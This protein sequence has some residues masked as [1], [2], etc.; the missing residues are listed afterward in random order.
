MTDSYN[1]ACFWLFERG[2]KMEERC[3]A[4]ERKLIPAVFLEEVKHFPESTFFGSNI[5][6]VCGFDEPQCQSLDLFV[7]VN[8]F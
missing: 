7:K 8:Y 5:N 4:S 1:V 6:V 3:V 2:V